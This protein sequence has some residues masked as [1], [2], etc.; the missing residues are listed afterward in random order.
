MTVKQVRVARQLDTLSTS[1]I[2]S[3]DTRN[4][5]EDAALFIREVCQS[6]ESKET[7]TQLRMRLRFRC[8][9]EG[10]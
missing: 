2:L 7:Y 6:I 8:L 4:A 9:Y 3:E 1:S 10:E 5:A